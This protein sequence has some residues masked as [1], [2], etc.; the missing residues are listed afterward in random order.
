ML[1]GENQSTQQIRRKTTIKLREGGRSRPGK[2]A[3]KSTRNSWLMI[4]G[5]CR[6]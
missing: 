6:T 5:G 1:A 4:H 3:E 2:S